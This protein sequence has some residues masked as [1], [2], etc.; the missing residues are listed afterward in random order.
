LIFVF[1]LR[2]PVTLRAAWL[3]HQPARMTFRH[4]MLLPR[5]EHCLTASFRA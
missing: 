1:S 5:M 3:V 2:R 4:S